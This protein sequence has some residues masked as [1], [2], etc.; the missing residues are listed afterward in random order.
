MREKAGTDPYR[1][2]SRLPG[3]PP[4]NSIAIFR[5]YKNRR[6]NLSADFLYM[7]NGLEYIQAAAILSRYRL[8]SQ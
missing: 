1:K 3:R 2:P 8:P 7:D 6:K 4:N 5:K